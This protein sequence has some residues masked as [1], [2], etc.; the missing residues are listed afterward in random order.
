[1]LLQALDEELMVEARRLGH[2]CACGAQ[3]AGEKEPIRRLLGLSPDVA[4][5]TQS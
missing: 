1:M 4:G 5:E 2:C 3:A